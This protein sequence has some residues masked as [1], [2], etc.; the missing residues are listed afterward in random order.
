MGKNTDDDLIKQLR[1]EG[2]SLRAIG[3]E[4]G[5]SHVAVLKRLKR[6]GM[7][8]NTEKPHIQTGETGESGNSE[9]CDKYARARLTEKTPPYFIKEGTDEIFGYTRFLAERADMKPFWGTLEE[10]REEKAKEKE[11][12]KGERD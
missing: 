8:G 11:M 3:R 6:M 12:P 7:V 10:F 4:L 1:A 9:F 2:K 5:V